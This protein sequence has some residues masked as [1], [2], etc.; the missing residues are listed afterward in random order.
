MSVNK[1]GGS[2]HHDLKH[3]EVGVKIRAFDRKVRLLKDKTNT[4]SADF[5]KKIQT[6][7]NKID[8]LNGRF[9][10]FKTTINQEVTTLDEKIDKLFKIVETN[11]KIMNKFIADM[12]VLKKKKN[13]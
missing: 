10:E 4:I 8:K 12:D 9:E 11:G 13:G 5:E 1:F 3:V 2:R 6:I 7:D